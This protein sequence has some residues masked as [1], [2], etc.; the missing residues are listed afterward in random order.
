MPW[1]FGSSPGYQARAVV[2][3]K[4]YEF[5]AHKCPS[6][7]VRTVRRGALTIERSIRLPNMP[8]WKMTSATWSKNAISGCGLLGWIYDVF[9]CS[10]PSMWPSIFIHDFLIFLGGIYG[11]IWFW[12]MLIQPPV[13]NRTSAVPSPIFRSPWCT[14]VISA[15]ILQGVASS[16]PTAWAKQRD[17]LPRRHRCPWPRE[18]SAPAMG[19][20]CTLGRFL[21][22]LGLK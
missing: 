20:M 10:F 19:E 16:Y 22:Q 1:K 13:L 5:C 3:M 21:W 17:G 14:T 4:S 12:Y 18:V 2:R 9:C 8:R 7:T 11:Y 6:S 15:G